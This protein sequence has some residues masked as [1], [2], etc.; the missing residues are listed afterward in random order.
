MQIEFPVT[1]HVYSLDALNTLMAP[2][3]LRAYHSEVDIMGTLFAFGGLGQTDETREVKQSGVYCL[4]DTV[5]PQGKSTAPRP[6]VLLRCEQ[7]HQ[8]EPQ[9]ASWCE[10]CEDWESF[11]HI[12]CDGCD[13]FQP[14]S[15]SNLTCHACGYNLCSAC[16]T[17]R[18]SLYQ[19]LENNTPLDDCEPRSNIRGATFVETLY[20]G[21]AKM[22][23]R[24]LIRILNKYMSAFQASSYRLLHN[25]CNHFASQLCTALTGNALPDW[26][27]KAATV[28]A[29]LESGIGAVA[30]KLSWL[31]AGV[32]APE[33]TP[34]PHQSPRKEMLVPAKRLQRKASSLVIT[35]A[36][37]QS[38]YTRPLDSWLDF[39]AL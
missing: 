21:K 17:K 28:G 31:G 18:C 32:T 4:G 1:V 23:K 39:S 2:V 13:T 14:V 10:A 36:K 8:L 3:G 33:S 29:G 34:A 12:R 26:V 7:Q 22:S 11:P 27:N 25:N 37:P 30:N 35:S 6:G 16:I 19:V 5:P 20:M 38:Y 9:G 15:S 24:Q